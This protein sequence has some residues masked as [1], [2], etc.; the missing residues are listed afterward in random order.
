MASAKG[1][2]IPSASPT[3][4]DVQS[5][6]NH[7][8]RAEQGSVN[9]HSATPIVFSSPSDTHP[10]RTASN[11]THIVVITFKMISYT[12]C[13]SLAQSSS[14]ISV[15]NQQIENT[16]AITKSG[17]CNRNSFRIKFAVAHLGRQRSHPEYRDKNSLI[18]PPKGKRG[19]LSP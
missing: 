9:C 19:P 1:K 12:A 11:T 7:C 13:Q 4:A 3:A 17:F 5:F 6:T 10:A 14:S 8:F 16:A 18:R 2:P 15:T